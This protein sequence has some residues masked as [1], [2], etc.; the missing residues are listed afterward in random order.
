MKTPIL[1]LT[2]ILFGAG[3]YAK[4]SDR[5]TGFYY[6][7]VSDRKE[8]VSF[9]LKSPDARSDIGQFA[10]TDECSSWA[11]NIRLQSKTESDL[12]YCVPGCSIVNKKI[13][14]LNRNGVVNLFGNY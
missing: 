4:G 14:C 1:L 5:W 11:K 3:C 9:I 13:D 8:S 7:S 2:L 6:F 10:S 12:F